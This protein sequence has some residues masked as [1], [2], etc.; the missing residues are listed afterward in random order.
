MQNNANVLTCNVDWIF[1]L[2]TRRKNRSKLL[3][4]IGYFE[5]WLVTVFTN[6]GSIRIWLGRCNEVKMELFLGQTIIITTTNTS[7]CI[8]SSDSGVLRGQRV[9]L[10][11]P[12]IDFKMGLAAFQEDKSINLKDTVIVVRDRPGPRPR[13]RPR[14]G[15][16][17]GPGPGGRGKKW[18]GAGDFNILKLTCFV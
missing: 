17:P 1:Y 12:R 3:E 14:P 7:F 16:R 10:I 8:F 18:P 11:M 2:V 6:P 9:D 15:Q 4:T 5:L 13:P